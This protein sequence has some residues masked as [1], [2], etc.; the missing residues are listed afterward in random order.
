MVY[1]F[2]E[3]FAIIDTTTQGGPGSS[4]N[5]LVYNVYKTAFKSFDYGSSGAQ[6]VILMFIVILLTI[7]QFR[8]V[9]RKVQY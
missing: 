4:T 6:S 8:Y 9:D 7:V 5:I 3:T 2:F 1:A